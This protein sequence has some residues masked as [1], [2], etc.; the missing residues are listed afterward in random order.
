[1]SKSV[2]KTENSASLFIAFLVLWFVWFFYSTCFSYFFGF[3]WSSRL[4]MGLIILFIDRFFTG[5]CVKRAPSS[6]WWVILAWLSSEWFRKMFWGFVKKKKEG[7]AECYCPSTLFTTFRVIWIDHP[8]LLQG[9]CSIKSGFFK[10]ICC[11]NHNNSSQ[12]AFTLWRWN[13]YLFTQSLLC[14]C[15]GRCLLPHCALPRL[16]KQRQWYRGKFKFSLC[17]L[18]RSIHMS[19]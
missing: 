14:F 3:I 10:I 11:Y 9:A 1:M 5:T 15:C 7:E 6:S 17:V 2:V 8:K 16:R 18:Y 13:F 19:V 4:A 12:L